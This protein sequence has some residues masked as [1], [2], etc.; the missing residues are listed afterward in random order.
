ME[1]KWKKESGKRGETRA[2]ERKWRKERRMFVPERKWREECEENKATKVE[3]G[4]DGK[5]GGEQVEE[6]RWRKE[7]R[8]KNLEEIK[9]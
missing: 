3:G 4:T 6:R 2:E 5:I 8:G 1:S 7:S 9:Q